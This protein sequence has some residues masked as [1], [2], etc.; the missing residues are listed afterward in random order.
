MCLCATL[1]VS[2]IL[3]TCLQTYIQLDSPSLPSPLTSQDLVPVF[4][5][6]LRGCYCRGIPIQHRII[7]QQAQAKQEASSLPPSPSSL[8]SPLTSQDLVPV[9][10]QRLRGC[11]CCRIPI[12]HRVIC[13]Q[14]NK[15]DLARTCLY[16]DGEDGKEEDEEKE[17]EGGRRRRSWPSNHCSD[18]GVVL[19]PGNWWAGA[20]VR[21]QARQLRCA[22][23]TTTT[24]PHLCKRVR[25]ECGRRGR[26]WVGRVWY[27]GVSPN[28]KASRASGRSRER[29]R[30][31]KTCSTW[32]STTRHI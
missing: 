20:L 24:G 12:Q 4:P 6:G 32:P 19:R 16:Q 2:R 15:F 3:I 18:D 29:G 21:W 13:Q 11:Y 10:P 17:E 14:R 9:F 8:P 28:E 22:V 23:T 7:Y 30:K 5:Q 25:V 27:A 26:A 31:Q 1:L